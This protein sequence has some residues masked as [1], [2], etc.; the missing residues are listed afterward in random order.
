MQ[1]ITFSDHFLNNLSHQKDLINFFSQLTREYKFGYCKI[2]VNDCTRN[3]CDDN[4]LMTNIKI[5]FQVWNKNE[6]GHGTQ[7]AWNCYRAKQ[8]SCSNSGFAIVK[9]VATV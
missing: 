9:E 4:K 6:S 8:F 5:T 3:D 7:W 1:T 2:H